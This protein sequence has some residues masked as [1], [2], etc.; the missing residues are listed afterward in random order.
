MLDEVCLGL[1]QDTVNDRLGDPALWERKH[2]KFGPTG[3][4]SG[5]T[6]PR[7]EGAFAHWDSYPLLSHPKQHVS[8]CLQVHAQE[9]GE[10][11]MTG[12]PCQWLQNYA[13]QLGLG[14][15]VGK[16]AGS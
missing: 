6:H 15:V 7:E 2:P 11:G 10:A 12:V 1:R 14:P 13:A 9:P 5:S 8:T 4:K 3:S 16:G